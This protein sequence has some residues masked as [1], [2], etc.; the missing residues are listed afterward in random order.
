[1]IS[2]VLYHYFNS[3]YLKHQ[4]RTPKQLEAHQQKRLNHFRK[5]ILSQSPFYKPY[6]D[7]PFHEWPM[8][9]KNIMMTHFDEINTVGIKK[10]E[11]LAL[12]F[13][14]EETR[15]FAPLIG[16]ISVGLSSGT[17]GQRGL[18]ITS[19]KERDAWAGI[20]LAK[21][22]PD[23]LLRHERIAL[24]LRANNRLYET[25]NKGKKIQFHF[26]DLLHDF[27]AHIKTLNQLQPTI[28]IAPATVLTLLA[29]D[30][31]L[32]IHP[33]KIVSVA[34]VLEPQDEQKIVAAFSCKVSQA[35][36]CT[37]GFLGISDN[38]NPGLILNEEFILIEKEWIDETRFVPIIT[39]L[40]RTSQPI[41]RY[42]LD[43]ILVVDT[44]IT[45]P[46]TR[47]KKIEGRVGDTLYGRSGDQYIP[48]FSDLIRQRIASYPEPIDD[49]QLTQVSLQEI[50]IEIT[51]MLDDINPLI[52]HLNQLFQQK[53]CEIPQWHWKELSALSIS[54]KRRRIKG[55]GICI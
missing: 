11:A 40:M 15:D 51:P 7:K 48:I 21:L 14:A 13:Q 22:L 35:Y 45:G 54:E 19:P 49:Y 43:D 39:D 50:H 27:A 3:I 32:K 52:N 28:L 37:E 2:R 33:K 47:I 8:C 30:A 31:A 16:N 10:E 44:K 1:M 18:F 17:S 24:F 20:M 25:L 23:G 29:S 38:T 26:F 9:N 12:A 46:K 6:A 53:H 34:E 42:R 5:K 4:L 55:M 36:Q 41:V